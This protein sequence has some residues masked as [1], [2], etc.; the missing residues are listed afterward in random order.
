MVVLEQ[1]DGGGFRIYI[2]FLLLL[3]GSLSQE[4][5]TLMRALG[6]GRREFPETMSDHVFKDGNGYPLAAVVYLDGLPNPF[7]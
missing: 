6:A 4:D 1:T 7:G 3:G 5:G 2:S